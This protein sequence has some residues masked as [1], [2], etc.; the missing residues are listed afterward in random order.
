MDGQAVLEH[1]TR[2]TGSLATVRDLDGLARAIHHVVENT[3]IV[4]Y[5]GIYMLDY[6]NDRLRL[7]YTKGFTAQEHEEAERTA[8]DRHPGWVIRNNQM[9][10]V[11]DTDKD[12]EGRSQSSNRSFRVRSR[13]WL[14]ITCDGKAI[15]AMGL[16]ST[17]AN[18][19]TSE[20]ISILQYAA[21][22]SGFMFANL[23]ARWALE[24]QFLVAEEQRRELVA[25]SSPA[26]EVGSG[27]VVLPIIGRMDENRAAQMTEK[28]LGLISGQ[29]IRVVILDL[30]GVATIDSASVEH[31]GRMHRAI[32]LLGSECVF[33]GISGQTAALMTEISQDLANW[34]TFANVRQALGASARTSPSHSRALAKP[35]AK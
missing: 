22:T 34:K 2:I 4:E 12:T 11:P 33:S 27:I 1:M 8:W 13:L 31:L 16:A 19:F 21:T 10:H 18:S 6:T 28:L 26:V 5:S 23:R 15:G 9:L 17:K 14:P 29:S 20:H 32:R 35:L 24:Q 25:L 7:W 30:T 3:A